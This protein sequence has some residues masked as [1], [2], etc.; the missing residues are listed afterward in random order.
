MALGCLV[1]LLGLCGRSTSDGTI[2]VVSCRGNGAKH[3]GPHNRST[4]TVTHPM[5]ALPAIIPWW[6]YCVVV[7]PRL[8]W[9]SKA[10]DSYDMLGRMIFVHVGHRRCV[11]PHTRVEK[12]QRG[13]IVVVRK[14][15]KSNKITQLVFGRKRFHAFCVMLL[16]SSICICTNAWCTLHPNRPLRLMGNGSLGFVLLNAKCPLGFVYPHAL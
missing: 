2:S 1:S 9:L 5:C 10:T 7:C 8:P 12:L 14:E 6:P 3:F 16:L 13:I 15:V 11:H 4:N